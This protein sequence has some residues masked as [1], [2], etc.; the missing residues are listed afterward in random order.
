M[1]N[2]FSEM[3]YDLIE[4]VESACPRRA[5]KITSQQ[6][7][8]EYVKSVPDITAE[9]SA[10]SNSTTHAGEKITEVVDDQ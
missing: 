7:N 5:T 4:K 8:P 1:R 2:E 6:G 10:N 9:F 3:W